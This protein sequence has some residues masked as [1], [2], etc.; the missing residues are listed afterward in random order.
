MLALAW[1]IVGLIPGF[2]A[3]EM[4][5]ARRPIVVRSLSNRVR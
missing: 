4:A 1:I 3:R 5:T 2:L